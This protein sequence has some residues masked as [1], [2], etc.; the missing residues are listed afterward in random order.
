MIAKI[1]K[2]GACVQLGDAAKDKPRF[3]SLK[4]GQS[5]FT[6]TLREALDLFK[7]ALPMTLGEYEGKEVVVGEGKF[8]PYVRYAG[9][10]VS[11]PRGTDPLTLTLAQAIALIREH[12]D[13]S[14]PLHQWGDLK[15]IKGRY[16]Y[17]IHTSGGN[18]QLPK[19]VEAESLTEAETRQI[20]AQ[21]TPISA[22]KRTFRRKSAK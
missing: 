22:R 21:G 6:I 8:G 7:T 15:V 14:T 17:Y 12:Q 20:V 2:I 4:K 3:V 1:S 18:Y 9:A 10:F 5:I 13:S 11:V 16:G 19:D